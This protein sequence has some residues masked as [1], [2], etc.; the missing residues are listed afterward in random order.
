MSIFVKRGTTR[1]IWLLFL[2]CTKLS[3]S[4]MELMTLRYDVTT[5]LQSCQVPYVVSAIDPLLCNWKEVNYRD[6]TTEF[7]RAF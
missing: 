7:N 4:L 2:F 5:F 3:W 1:N 6:E